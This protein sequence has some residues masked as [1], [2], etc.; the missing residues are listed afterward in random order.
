MRRKLSIYLSILVLLINFV[1][2]II[3]GF[4]VFADSSPTTSIINTD[5]LD[6]SYNVKEAQKNYYWEI[7]Y[8]I[9]EN[10]KDEELKLKFQFNHDKEINIT[11]EEGWANISDDYITSDFKKSGKGIIRVS[12]TKDITKLSIKIQADSRSLVDKKITENILTEDD[13]ISHD[14]IIPSTEESS[15]ESSTEES[16]TESS[17]EESSTESSTEESSTESSTEESLTASTIYPSNF[18]SKATLAS[19]L[20]N[21]SNI[22]PDYTTDD[23]RGTFPTYSWIPT[24][25]TTVINHQGKGASLNQWDGVKSWNG[26]PD[27]KTNSYIEYAGEKN[28]VDFAIRKYAKETTTPGLYDVYLNVRGNE[29][30]PI[31]PID[32][33]LVIDMSGSMKGEKALAVQKGVSDFLTNIQKTA[34]SKYV[35]VGVVGYSSPANSEY[36]TTN[37]TINIDNLS[38]S[39]H[40]NSINEALSQP[41]QGGTFTQLGI[42][43]GTDMLE[44]DTND[45]QKMMIVLTD[46]V[47]TFSYKV[48]SASK[49]DN[50]IYGETFASSRNEP[51]NTSKIL[52]SYSVTDINGGELQIKDTWAATLGEAKKSKS[53]GNEI[54]TLGIQLDKDKEYLTKEEVRSRTSLIASDGLYQDADNASEITEYLVSQADDILNRFNTINNGSIEDPL[55][56]QFTYQ[57]TTADVRSVGSSQISEDYLPKVEIGNRELNASNLNIGKNQEIQIHYQVH[58]NTEKNDF[59][60]NRWYPLNGKTTLTPNGNIPD[61][62]VEFGVPSAKGEGINLTF[63]KEWEEYNGDTSSRPSS[64]TYEVTRSQLTSP[65]AWKT[66]YINVEGTKEQDTWSKDTNQLA[67]QKDGQPELWLPKYNAQGEKFKYTISNEISVP[68]Y[69]SEKV[70]DTTY[71]NVKQFQPLSLEVTKEDGNGKKLSGAEFELKDINDNIIPVSKNPNGSIFTFDNLSTGKYTLEEIKAPEG[72]VVLKQKIVVEIKDDGSVFVDNRQVSVEGNLIK[73]IVNNQ[74]KGMLPSTGGKGPI[75]YW[76]VSGILFILLLIIGSIYLLKRRANR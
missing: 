62:K 6:I 22:V 46:G 14:L 67:I 28:P 50:V 25:N 70:D 48:N 15:T 75:M 55:G 60:P 13:S 59:V 19:N 29:Q 26:D 44:E 34:Y 7:N 49:I 65:D 71:K 4:K 36:E 24:D 63:N 45:H 53:K 16:S 33:V 38:S 54:H 1:P 76:I 61:N 12:S 37:F 20:R 35:N 68:G 27:N 39:N 73:L 30:N 5:N 17:T 69:N 31:K 32:I 11:P 64:V 40:V 9:K 42:R 41:Y 74:Q 2:N 18:G 58:L 10:Q 3:Q 47:P 21:Y 52:P 72:Y 66:G 56:S 8:Q 43:K 51:G 23:D 57:G